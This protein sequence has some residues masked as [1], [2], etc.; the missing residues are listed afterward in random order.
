M[1]SAHYIKITMAGFSNSEEPH[2]VVPLPFA[3]PLAEVSDSPELELTPEKGRSKRKSIISTRQ[4]T[5]PTP[6]DDLADMSTP[7][8]NSTAQLYKQLQVLRSEWYNSRREEETPLQCCAVATSCNVPTGRPLKVGHIGL[9]RI[10]CGYDFPLLFF[11][12]CTFR[13]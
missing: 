5:L 9:Y 10:I 8:L 13:S 6:K 11:H 3:H 1:C 7:K 4:T 12:F 2:L